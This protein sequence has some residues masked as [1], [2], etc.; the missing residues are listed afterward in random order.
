MINDLKKSKIFIIIIILVI[1]IVLGCFISSEIKSITN[2]NNEKYYKAQKI[3]NKEYFKDFIETNTGYVLAQGKVQAV[4][5]VSINE[6]EG[7][8]LKIKKVKE[9]Y[10]KHTRSIKHKINDTV[11][12]TTEEYREWDY[13]GEEEMHVEIFN[14][15]GVDFNYEKVK[16]SND[17]YKTTMD[18]EYNTRYKYYIIPSEFETTLFAYV[19]NNTV[20]DYSF[21]INKTIDEVIKDKQEEPKIYCVI[22]WIVW[23][24]LILIIIFCILDR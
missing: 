3:D 14:F 20:N 2:K 16:F 9:Q 4:E 23:V 7:K 13:M 21:F 10:N 1:L 5:G 17:R 11:Y 18:G 8:Y 12:Y 24:S 19:E 22:F 6:L 15:L